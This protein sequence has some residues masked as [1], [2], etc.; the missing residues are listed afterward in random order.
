MA[1]LDNA[2]NTPLSNKNNNGGDVI[3][4]RL[5]NGGCNYTNLSLGV[6]AAK[7]GCKRFWDKNLASIDGGSGKTGFCMCEHHACF[8]DHNGSE[9]ETEVVGGSNTPRQRSFMLDR[10]PQDVNRG[11]NPEPGGSFP[12]LGLPDSVEWSRYMH[13]SPQGLPAIPSQC[14]LPS[15]NGSMTSGSQSGYSRPFGGRGLDTLSHVPRPGDPAPQASTSRMQIYVDRFGVQHLQSLTDVATPSVR[16]SQDEEVDLTK[17]ATSVANRLET[18]VEN[19]GSPTSIALRIAPQAPTTQ[20]AFKQSGS[21]VVDKNL[22]SGR[23]INLVLH[24]QPLREP[25]DMPMRV[26]NHEIR[27]DELENVSFRNPAVCDLEE[28]YELMD[29]RVMEL[30]NR[31]EEIE[32]IQ[33]GLSDAAS[34]NTRQSIEGSFLSDTSSALIVAAM[35]NIDSSRVEALEAQVAELQAIAP[36]SYLRPWEVEVV[37]LPFG[38]RLHGIWSTRESMTPNSRTGST[39]IDDWTQTQHNSLALAQACLASHDQQTDWERS[40]SD[41]GEQETTWLMAKA[42]AM[43]TRVDNRL[44]SRGLVRTIQICGPDARDVQAAMLKEFGELPEI[45]AEDPFA[46]QDENT[47]EIPRNLRSYIGLQATWIP[48]RKLHKDNCLRFLNPA[49]MVTP[50]LWTVPF[51]SSSVAMRQAGTRRLYVTQRDSYVQSHSDNLVN[52]TWQKLRQLPRV[53]PETSS[54]IHTPEA[55]AQEECWAYDARLDPPPSHHA[56]AQS[57]FHSQISQLSIE[58]L[59][60]SPEEQ[61]NNEMEMEPISPSDH[62]SSAAVSPT[63]STPRTSIPPPTIPTSPNRQRNPFRPVH[64]PR[65]ISMSSLI[66]IKGEPTSQQN[67]TT[68]RRITSLEREREVQSSP[69]T[70]SQPLLSKRR[71]ISRSPSRP[72][73]TPRWSVGGSTSPYPF[74]DNDG[75]GTTP[76]AY[77]TPHSNAPYVTRSGADID[78]YED[79]NQDLDASHHEDDQERESTTDAD[80]DEEEEG[81]YEQNALSDYDEWQGVQDD[82]HAGFVSGRKLSTRPQQQDEEKSEDSESPSEYPSTHPKTSSGSEKKD[83]VRLYERRAKQNSDSD[84]ASAS[85]R[86]SARFR[87]HVDEEV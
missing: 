63:T 77:A 40:A 61:I 2:P 65:T 42:C 14:L 11:G 26:A 1:A 57:S 67:L 32:K 23:G 78:V 64:H 5:P 35:N 4:S 47:G 58:S 82:R 41:L 80:E 3:E 22:T 44:R 21:G 31:V 76:F 6:N 81:G 70:A 54:F 85:A 83:G 16:T 12:D 15:D 56:S 46:S 74:H 75:R 72:R 7:C 43:N 55:D 34:V 62:F 25:N 51:L 19:Q 20:M 8:H 17:H 48:L 33:G 69:I 30:E 45:L 59:P 79:D 86:G 10:S 53:Y 66:P 37:F 13:G 87:I 73:N 60:G 38:T 28:S 39:G 29:T 50:A 9:R 49:E 71:R 84:G 36:P 68:K 18:I 24:E 52:W 27:L